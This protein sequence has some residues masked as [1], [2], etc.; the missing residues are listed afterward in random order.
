M[1]LRFQEIFLT[2]RLFLLSGP[3]D[4]RIKCN[5][6]ITLDRNNCTFNLLYQQKGVNAL[7]QFLKQDIN[8]AERFNIPIMVCTPTQRANE[9][10][11]KTFGYKVPEA[12]TKINIDAVKFVQSLRSQYPAF[13]EGIFATGVIGPSKST[14]SSTIEDYEAYHTLQADAYRTAKADVVFITNMTNKNE[15]IGAARVAA[16]VDTSY[17]VGFVATEQGTLLDGTPIEAL[18]QEI[19]FTISPRPFFYAITCTHISVIRKA[20]QRQAP[21][22][23]RI[24]GVKVHEHNKTRQ[25]FAKMKY[26]LHTN[27][28]RF[29]KELKEAAIPN[30]IKILSGCCGTDHRHLKAICE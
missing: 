12:V 2:E 8:I 10:Y 30:H 6:D 24:L 15:A 16:K 22:F 28:E 29:A 26:A 13:D 19:D 18:I 14:Q 27:P 23:Q 1:T 21:Q 5:T 3:L 17:G 25:Q 4:T 20:L 9:N 11:I 7:T